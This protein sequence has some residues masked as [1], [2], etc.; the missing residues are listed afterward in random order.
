MRLRDFR[1]IARNKKSGD[2][3]IVDDLYF[4]EE[5]GIHFDGDESYGIWEIELE[6]APSGI[7]E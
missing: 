3:Q 2:C 7:K 4:F 6:S 1:I 5:Q